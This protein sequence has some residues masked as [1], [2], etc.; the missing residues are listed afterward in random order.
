MKFFPRA[1]QP[2]QLVMLGGGSGAALRQ[3]IDSVWPGNLGFAVLIV[4]WMGA[5]ALGALITGIIPKA[6]NRAWLGPFW[7]PGFLGGFT[8]MS[9]VALWVNAEARDA[10]V[11]LAALYLMLTVS[12]S[13]TSAWLGLR[14]GENG[15]R[16][17]RAAG[18]Q[19][20][21]GAG[22]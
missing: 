2:W 17:R 7:G 3:L 1:L 16:F 12:G 11:G 9:G 18:T 6:R 14:F 13:L 22:S 19:P 8:T 4:N 10:G 20:Q 21:L 15:L 5:F